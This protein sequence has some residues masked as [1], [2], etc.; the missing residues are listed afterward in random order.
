MRRW[1][2]AGGVAD[3]FCNLSARVNC[4]VA[5]ASDF[6]EIGGIPNA[7]IGLAFYVA[8]GVALGLAARGDQWAKRLLV[9]GFGLAA[10]YSLFLA[11]VLGLVLRTFCPGCAGLYVVNVAGLVLARLISGAPYLASVSKFFSDLKGMGGST[12][13]F[14]FLVTLIVGVGVGAF[15]ADQVGARLEGDASEREAAAKVW[16][17]ETFLATAPVSAEE[18]A[19]LREG[20]ARGGEGAAVTIVEISDFECP[21]CAKVVPLMEALER[22]YGDKVRVVFRHNPLGMH[23]HAKGAALGAICAQEQGA[24]WP[25]HDK[26][27]GNQRA[28]KDE[29]LR[30]YA[31]EL[32]LDVEAFGACLGGEGA[33]A[34][35]ER[36]RALIKR[37]KLLGTPM[38]Y[39]NGRLIKGAVPLEKLKAAVDHA[40]ASP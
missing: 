35:L 5:A 32:G 27:F 16:L 13:V 22:D 4:N 6:A 31:G 8:C 12:A 37:L 28:L 14:A 21:F 7:I 11:G 2:T 24:F 33:K 30:R 19:A 23:P 25:M 34:A 3:G 10:V 29:D 20:P 1:S 38:I 39:V 40:L 26:L 15:G 36:D 18:W 17:E 9:L